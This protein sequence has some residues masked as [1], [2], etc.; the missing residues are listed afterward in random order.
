MITY[1]SFFFF[2][3]F[4]E[5]VQDIP[6][7]SITVANKLLFCNETIVTRQAIS[8]SQSEITSSPTPKSNFLSTTVF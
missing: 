3:F 4:V 8:L 1:Y 2:N 5:I 6:S 7:L